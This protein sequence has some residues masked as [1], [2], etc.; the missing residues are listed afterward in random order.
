MAIPR[1]AGTVN[2][3]FKDGVVVILAYL[4]FTQWFKDNLDRPEMG[5]IEYGAAAAWPR[6]SLP[7]EKYGMCSSR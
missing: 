6:W 4:A 5:T 2:G 1:W 3:G 7:L